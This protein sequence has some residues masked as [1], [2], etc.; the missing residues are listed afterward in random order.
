VYTVAAAKALGTCRSLAD[1]ISARCNLMSILTF[2]LLN[3][4][5][6]RR[7]NE[8][9][10]HVEAEKQPWPMQFTIFKTAAACVIMFVESGRGACCY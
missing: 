8:R 9:V 4:S 3:N 7:S 1:A 2:K 10:E 6:L 5:E